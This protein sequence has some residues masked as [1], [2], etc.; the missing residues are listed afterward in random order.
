MINSLFLQ[1]KAPFQAWGL[2]A[3][4]EQRDTAA[5]PT[6][7]AV[8][9]LIGCALGLDRRDDR[10]RTLSDKLRMGVRVDQ[11]GTRLIDY[12]TTGGVKLADG[13]PSGVLNAK[14]EI[15]RETD[16]SY[17]HYLVDAAFLV[18]LQGESELI[19]ELAWAVQHPIYPIYLGRKA[20]VPSEPV[21]AGVG[22]YPDLITALSDAK[23]SSWP[24]HNQPHARCIVEC[25]PHEG[26]RQYDQIWNPKARRFAA[27]TIQ[28]ISIATGV[29]EINTLEG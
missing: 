9:G 24:N 26:N 6:K 25:L 16:V 17:R 13:L 7:S 2:R 20:C 18:V 22:D 23:H 1:L 19:E 5:E 29:A 21:Y 4:W 12:H 11:Q 15:K 14:G 28:T 10:L 8:I 27:R 3:H